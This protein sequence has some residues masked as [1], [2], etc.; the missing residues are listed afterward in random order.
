M[1]IYPSPTVSQQLELVDFGASQPYDDAFI[2]M[3]KR[4]LLSAVDGRKGDCIALS[5]EIGYLTETDNEVSLY[6]WLFCQ[7]PSVP[8]RSHLRNQDADPQTSSP[9]CSATSSQ[10]VCASALTPHAHILHSPHLPG[11]S[12]MARLR[13]SVRSCLSRPT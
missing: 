1:A 10:T 7:T 2:G 6:I 4:L 5:R 12:G 8:V 13:S 9:A 11:S 3:Y